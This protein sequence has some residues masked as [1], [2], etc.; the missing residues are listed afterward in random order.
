MA[1]CINLSFSFFMAS[2]CENV[3]LQNYYKEAATFAYN[4]YMRFREEMRE[5]PWYDPVIEDNRC[6]SV[7]GYREGDSFRGLPNIRLFHGLGG[8]KQPIGTTTV[9][10]KHVTF[11]LIKKI[12]LNST[13]FMYSIVSGTKLEMKTTQPRNDHYARRLGL[14]GGLALDVLGLEILALFHEKQSHYDGDRGEGS[15]TDSETHR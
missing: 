1:V 7:L 3:P 12:L 8:Y 14:N 15:Q 13:S 2:F 6:K 11:H 9:F 5:H 10:L 4:N